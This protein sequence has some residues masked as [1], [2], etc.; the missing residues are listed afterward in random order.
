[1]DAILDGPSV[2]N[3]PQ[4]PDRPNDPDRL[5]LSFISVYLGKISTELTSTQ[6]ILFLYTFQRSLG[7]LT[8]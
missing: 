1:M 3:A 6:L 7:H 4:T 8:F 5:G 2:Q